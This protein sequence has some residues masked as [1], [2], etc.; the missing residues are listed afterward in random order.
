MKKRLHS[1]LPGSMRTLAFLSV[2]SLAAC[3]ENIALPDGGGDGDGGQCAVICTTDVDCC[4]GEE[5]VDGVC[6]VA[7]ACPSGC[8]FE[9]DKAG[10]QVCNRTTKKCVSGAPPANC[11]DDCDCFSGEVCSG[12]VCVP[13]GGD[14][15][16]CIS[17]D[18]CSEGEVCVNGRCRPESCETREDC[19]GEVC[20]VCKDGLCVEPAAVCH[21]DEECCVGYFCN[22]SEC[23]LEDTGC[24]SDSDCP[25]PGQVCVD[26]RCIGAGC[27][28]EDCATGQWCDSEAGLCRPGCDY[29][30]DCMAP[31]T[32]DYAN[33][34]C[35]QADCCG[36]VCTP[37]SQYCD[38]VSCRCVD[39]D[40]CQGDGDCPPNYTCRLAD[41]TCVC[42]DAAC[43]AGS[44]CDD[45]SGE[46][47]ADPPYCD[48]EVFTT[49]IDCGDSVSG[50]W[51][52]ECLSDNQ[53]GSYARQFTFEGTAGLLI[54]I[55]LTSA[56]DTY[57]VLI[58]PSGMEEEYDD[59]GGDGTNSRISM[60]LSSTGT[61]TIEATT[62]YSGETGS[63]DLSLRCS[64][65]EDCT[66]PIA[67]GDT[68][69]GSWTGV[70]PSIHQP[71]SY[72]RLYTFEGI[73]GQ[74]VAIDLTS[75]V[76]TY[77][78]LI[79]P[80]GFEE[81]Y[82]DD[83]DYGVTDSRISRT[84]SGTGTYTIEATTYSSG[85]T[86]SF[87]LSLRCPNCSAPIACGDRL[88]GSWT[89]ECSSD[90]QWDSYGRLY[91]FDGTAG[92]Q[93]TIDLTSSDADT[94]L[95]LIDSYGFEEDWNDDWDFGSDSRISR[96]LSSTGTY[97]IE[98]TTYFSGTTG[99]FDL[100]LQCGARGT[101]R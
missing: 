85:E 13:V 59:D 76:D 21:G 55:D 71:G 29:N 65:A 82:N 10:G 28:P 90:R 1:R 18:D 4:Q 40:G 31:E 62:Y 30:D 23:A 98:A 81:D 19:A 3:G 22:F 67:C 94:Y 39:V 46:C 89:G 5:C 86:G 56:V 70:C 64:D 66:S 88:S 37:G 12:G 34:V 60:A 36:G 52:G 2:L 38:P 41:G 100:S 11:I 27:T 26:D 47:V 20:L 44:H 43:S 73:A 35:G 93:V 97:T 87:D 25:I 78:I 95:Y 32:C 74:H 54:V 51:I 33:H 16:G 49:A 77:L 69:S 99:D 61:Y 6:V 92:Q 80:N 7:D 17:D 53:P 57:M 42:T 84:L 48:P 9:C 79:D 58:D 72:A 24:Q 14:L 63:F 15:E 75:S 83:A 8:N 45:Q 101:T 96:A 68:L 91:T 50:S